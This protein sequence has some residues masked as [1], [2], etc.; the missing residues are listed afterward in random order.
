MLLKKKGCRQQDILVKDFSMPVNQTAV[1]TFYVLTL[2]NKEREYCLLQVNKSSDPS[3]VSNL[4]LYQSIH[5]HTPIFPHPAALP[6][7]E[8]G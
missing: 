4:F 2:E 7:K 6:C 8:K 3:G 1:Y 5:L